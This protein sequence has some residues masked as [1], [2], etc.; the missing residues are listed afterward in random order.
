VILALAVGM[1][2]SVAEPV[3][4]TH[5]QRAAQEWQ[6]GRKPQ[7]LEAFYIGQLRGRINIACVKQP[8]DGGPALL[9]ALQEVIGRPINEW[10][11][12]EIDQWLAG[13]DAA[14]AWD[15]A[16]P[17]PDVTTPACRQAQA[18][19]RSGLR[20]LRANIENSR[21][22]IASKRKKNGL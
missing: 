21:A 6:A 4:P 1:A 11:G 14:L 12:G 9:G 5:Y 3:W 10:A 7:A 8:E 22:E 17:D 2:A 18:T 20:K 16:H 13:I 19:Q 15:A